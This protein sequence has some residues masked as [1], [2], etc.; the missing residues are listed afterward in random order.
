LVG[1]GIAVLYLSVFASFSFYR[2]VPQVVAFMMMSAVTVLAFLQAFRYDSL[3]VSCLGLLGG[4]LTPFLLSTGEANEVGLFTYI[5]LLDAG[6]FAVLLM[7]DRW[8]ILEPLSL[9]ATY[10]VYLLWYKEHYIADDLLTTAY[11]LIIFWA[12]FYSL[13]I[14]RSLRSFGSY[15]LVRTGVAAANALFFYS[16]LYSIIEPMHHDVMGLVT[17]LFGAVY[18]LTALAVQRRNKDAS[19]SFSRQILIAIAL[20][21]VATAIQFTG[22][23]T[24]L[25]WSVEALVLVYC[26]LKWNFRLA[27][28][29][30]IAV[31]GFA[32]LK[33]LYNPDSF[34]SLP[35]VDASLIL[36]QRALTFAT[37]AASMGISAGWLKKQEGK[38]QM[39]FARILDYIWPAV[40]FALL[41]VETTGYFK[42]IKLV[43]AEESIDG[44][45][46]KQLMSLSVIWMMYSIPLLW[47]G[48]NKKVTPW[49]HVALGVAP[50][51][52]GAFCLPHGY[53]RV[54]LRT[55]TGFPVVDE[56]PCADDASCCCRNNS[57]S[58]MVAR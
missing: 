21:V 30:A 7:K 48:I 50:W 56:F 35:V 13:E 52:C 26:G 23:K 19:A 44:I 41:T 6:I 28:I 22:F 10:L 8:A 17:F 3:A 39:L 16:A 2:L 43:S 34:S 51:C 12:L 25:W 32:L 4:F 18:F 24:V 36:N 11:F 38:P 20:L 40:V 9:G 55:G 31:Y 33:L 29:S 5:A 27:W 54:E 57:P 49:Q 15:Q 46:F 37:L 1:S 53:S 47:F 58:A 42:S 14:Y 45:N